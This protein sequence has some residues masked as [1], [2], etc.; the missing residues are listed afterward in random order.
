MY[1][2][3]VQLDF[4][5]FIPPEGPNGTDWINEATENDRD[6]FKIIIKRISQ[7]SKQTAD[8]TKK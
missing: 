3:H 5:E 6:L 1:K 4:E 7:Y 2:V 8:L